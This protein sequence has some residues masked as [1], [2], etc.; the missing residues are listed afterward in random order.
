M[1]KIIFRFKS[2]IRT[3]EGIYIIYVEIFPKLFEYDLKKGFLQTDMIW[4]NIDKKRSEEKSKQI[5]ELCRL[6]VSKEKRN[7][8]I[9]SLWGQ[10]QRESSKLIS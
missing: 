10:F 9:S 2:L 6:K 4:P 5:S 8:N 1:I 7:E 3:L